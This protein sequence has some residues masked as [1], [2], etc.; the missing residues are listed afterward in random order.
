VP[1]NDFSKT[2]GMQRLYNREHFF[3][4]RRQELL[5]R[6]EFY[7]LKIISKP[8]RGLVLDSCLEMEL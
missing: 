1:R 5:S 8:Q 2:P 3:L 6:A 7:V 4:I